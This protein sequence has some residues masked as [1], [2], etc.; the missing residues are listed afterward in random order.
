MSLST[1][2]SASPLP[3]GVANNLNWSQIGTSG[4]W[5]ANITVPNVKSTSALSCTLQSTVANYANASSA[6]LVTAQP[7]TNTISFVVASDP[8]AFSSNFPISWAVASF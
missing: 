3:S 2:A 8:T 6:W 7:S 1:L 5:S 4:Y